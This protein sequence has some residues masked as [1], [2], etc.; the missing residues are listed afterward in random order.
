MEGYSA[1]KK[2]KPIGDLFA[3]YKLTFYAPQATVE[4]ACIEVI[5]KVT[6]LT[7]AAEQVKY[8]VN[9]K[10]LSVQ[11]PSILKSELRFHH[12]TVLTELKKTL[13]DKGSPESIR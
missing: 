13:G 11:V 9:T 8:N 3:K 4:K 6:G 7:I 12:Q 10:T 5:H 2:M 1:P